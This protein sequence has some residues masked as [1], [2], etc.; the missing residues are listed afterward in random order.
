MPEIRRYF[1]HFLPTVRSLALREPKGSRRQII[2]FIGLFQHLEDLRLLQCW[3]GTQYEPV[4]DLT[5][6]PPSAPPLRG[7]LLISNFTRVDLLKDMIDLLGGIRFRGMDFFDVDDMQLLLGG[8]AKTLETFQL[9]LT[10]PRGKGVSLK[11]LQ[12]LADGFAAE[13]SL[14]DFDLS[15][16]KSLQTLEVSARSVEVTLSGGSL[17]AAS[18]LLQY[19]LSTIQSPVFFQVVVF[20]CDRDLCG[21]QPVRFSYWAPS[22]SQYHG[23]FEVFREA[24]KV[25]DF[26]LVLCANVPDPVRER[27]VRVLKRAV[28]A[29]KAKNGFDDFF[30]APSVTYRPYR[31]RW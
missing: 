23:Q 17:D 8:C 21:P 15:H 4:D 29:E 13:S 27:S 11:H 10:D 20:Y 24:R 30:P 16:N 19:A 6:I 28:A 31:D 2:Y 9:H 12:Y 7:C 22:A 26:R 18:M 1:G 5:L 14:W 3:A 25:R